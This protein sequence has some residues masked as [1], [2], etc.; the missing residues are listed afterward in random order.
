MPTLQETHGLMEAEEAA[1]ELGWT[2]PALRA[3][4]YRREIPFI[5][6]GRRVYF[7][8]PQLERWLLSCS[9]PANHKSG[10]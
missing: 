8:K 1:Q 9:S 10:E 6:V 4:V 2:V 5:R 7:S 3:R